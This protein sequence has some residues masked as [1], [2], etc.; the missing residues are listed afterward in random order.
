LIRK[1]TSQQ[2]AALD[3]LECYP[4]LRLKWTK[5]VY[6]ANEAGQIDEKTGKLYFDQYLKGTKS[7]IGTRRARVVGPLPYPFKCCYKT[8]ETKR[9][10]LLLVSSLRC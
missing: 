9:S 7:V 5:I 8:W 4:I 6:E 1:V 10:H 2:E 3:D